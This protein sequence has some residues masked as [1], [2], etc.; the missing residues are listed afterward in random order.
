MGD[1]EKWNA[2]YREEGPPSPP[3]PFLVGLDDL[4]PRRGR[5][6]D[7]AGGTGRHALWLALS[8]IHI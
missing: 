6:L 2:R 1:R 3:S 8:L 7:V 5:A 4:L